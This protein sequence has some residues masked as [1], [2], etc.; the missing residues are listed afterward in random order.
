[1]RIA[2]NNMLKQIN[3]NQSFN[4]CLILIGLVKLPAFLMSFKIS[5]FIRGDS[6][7]Y[8]TIAAY[9]ISDWRF[10]IERPLGYPL[11]IKLCGLNVHYV[12]IAQF[13]FSIFA[14]ALLIYNLKNSLNIKKKARLILLYTILV[15]VASIQITKWDNM[16]FAESLT[17]SS[18][19]LSIIIIYDIYTNG[20]NIVKT[21]LLILS[22]LSLKKL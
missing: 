1:M 7:Q 16:V 9:N 6:L 11:F 22:M 8:M 21:T 5:P 14:W 18:L 4:F 20:K 19:C 17:L 3:E 13:I 15:I 12:A 2:L 10:F